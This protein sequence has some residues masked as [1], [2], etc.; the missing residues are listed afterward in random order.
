MTSRHGKAPNLKTRTAFGIGALSSGLTAQAITSLT[1]LFYNQVVGMSAT[2]VGLALMI[3]LV[4]DAL[5]DPAIGVWTDRAR[6]RFGRRHPFMYASIIPAS[7][8]FWALWSPP[9]GLSETA[10]FLYLLIT[11]IA[12]RFF[13]SFYEIASTALIP[14]MAPDYDARTN[15]IAGRFFWGV[16]GGVLA[17][18]LAF[19]LY[20]ADKAGGVTNMA[21]Y[22]N[23]GFASAIIIAVTL[24]ISC[25]GTHSQIPHLIQPPASPLNFRDIAGQMLSA[26]SNRNFAAIMVG[27]LFAGISSGISGGLGVYFNIYFWGLS[28]DQM[29]LL[30]GPVLLAATF[31]V[32]IAPALSRRWGKKHVAMWTYGLSM[33]GV[34]MP[35]GLRL[36][37][38]LP[39]NNWPWLL[40]FLAV[41]AFVAAALG[42]IGLVVIV[43][44]LADVVEENAVKTGQRSEGLFFSANSVLTKCV[45]GV[46]TLIAGLLL[47]W[48]DFP[49]NAK[50]GEISAAMMH[51]LGIVYVPVGMVLGALAIYCV[52]F[53]RID[54]SQ[55]E[56]NLS[57]LESAAL[58]QAATIEGGEPVLLGVPAIAGVR[59]SV[60]GRAST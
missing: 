13:I 23:Y 45:T 55:H 14:E 8:A 30:I 56:A 38:I 11:L 17:S 43:S 46:G 10:N 52:S 25:V 2:M 28:T 32:M 41:E 48:V 7:L 20:L 44:M 35:I 26:F 50:P 15:L 47:S 49:A 6:S 59:G 39:G 58:A 12:A 21:G 19:Q 22:A 42:L 31:G 16:I 36:L 3:S 57:K 1:L 18:L 24:L 37:G 54:R 9:P 51:D 33:A 4:G 53:Y 60:A 29:S 27:S 5:W 40:P 34:V